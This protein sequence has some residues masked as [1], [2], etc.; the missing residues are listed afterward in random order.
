MY[1]IENSTTTTSVHTAQTSCDAVNRT[2]L[3]ATTR[4]LR[5][6]AAAI[7]STKK[8]TNMVRKRAQPAV[9]FQKHSFWVDD[10]HAR[11][12]P[13]DMLMSRARSRGAIER[14]KATRQWTYSCQKEC[15]SSISRWASGW[16]NARRAIV[17]VVVTH[18]LRDA[19]G[20]GHETSRVPARVVSPASFTY[21]V[22]VWQVLP[23]VVSYIMGKTSTYK[24]FGDRVVKATAVCTL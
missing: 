8:I 22:G 23:Y 7:S 20:K 4:I 6:T 13:R 18:P 12:T 19:G 24:K 14:G 10:M 9:Q 15:G 21:Y 3:E 17:P 2:F 5:Y 11:R 16:W 1:G